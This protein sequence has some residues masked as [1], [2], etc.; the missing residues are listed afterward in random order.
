MAVPR[1][2]AS[3][4]SAGELLDA[5]EAASGR[6][7]W[8]RALALLAAGHD[9]GDGA[10]AALP[11][12]ERDRRL[13]A[14]RRSVFGTSVQATAECPA[15]A[16]PAELSFA[17]DDVVPA[18]PP[19]AGASA[20]T[21]RAAGHEV[22][23]RLPTSADLATVAAAQPADARDAAGALLARCVLSVTAP[24]GT[25]VAAGDLPGEVADAVSDA[26]AAADGAADLALALTCPSCGHRWAAPF[27]IAVFVWQEV[28]A[29]AE[30]ILLEVDG[31]AS[32]YGWQEPA[33]LALSPWR[34]RRYLEL[35]GR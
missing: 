30:R 4:I 21:V 33:V 13:V 26:I 6:P 32:A 24:S 34:R 18:T 3:Q 35:A 27:D 23:F 2:K 29:W 20:G 7:E 11:V 8:A 15:C 28:D 16:E 5:W 9:D 22:A 19:S 17:L 14:L 31:L 25:A 12:G 1:D 10:L